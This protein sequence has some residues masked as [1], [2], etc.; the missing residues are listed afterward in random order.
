MQE[1]LSQMEIMNQM[2]LPFKNDVEPRMDKRNSDSS[3]KSGTSV[4]N[5]YQ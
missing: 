4:S 1:K 2:H 5:I 3:I